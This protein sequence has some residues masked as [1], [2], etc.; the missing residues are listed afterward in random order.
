MGTEDD[1]ESVEIAKRSK[2]STSAMTVRELL[3]ERKRD[4]ELDDVGSERVL[5]YLERSGRMW[6]LMA[7]AELVVI[8]MIVAGL[9]S[10]GVTGKIPGVGD[11]TITPREAPASPS[12][13]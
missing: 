4:R 10:V 8:G 6:F 5:K 3:K 1:S 13:P 11:I 12:R 2:S 9:L 7:M